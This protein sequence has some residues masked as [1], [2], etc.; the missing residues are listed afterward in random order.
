MYLEW[1]HTQFTWDSPGLRQVSYII[2][3]SVHFHSQSCTSLDN[4][5]VDLITSA[6]AQGT[7]MSIS[8]VKTSTVVGFVATLP[9]CCRLPAT[10]LVKTASNQTCCISSMV[11]RGGHKAKNIKIFWDGKC[12]ITRHIALSYIP[13]IFIVSLLFAGTM[14]GPGNL[15]E[16]REI[17]ALEISVSRERLIK[18]IIVV[19]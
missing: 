5:M 16:S 4:Y 18:D 17:T 10:P 14:L 6:K 12:Q 19:M 11:H 2:I 9:P 7:R 1:P 15:R 13:N 3:N 8:Y